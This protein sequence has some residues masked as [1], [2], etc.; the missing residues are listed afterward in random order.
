[1]ERSEPNEKVSK[2]LLVSGVLGWFSDKL[3]LLLLG[4]S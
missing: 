3:T 2:T 1:M 4:L